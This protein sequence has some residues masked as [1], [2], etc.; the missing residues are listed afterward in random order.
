MNYCLRSSTRIWNYSVCAALLPYDV[1]TYRECWSCTWRRRCSTAGRRGSSWM[2]RSWRS[3]LPCLQTDNRR[4]SV[5]V[6]RPLVPPGRLQVRGSGRSHST[7]PRGLTE[8]SVTLRLRL[9]HTRSPCRRT[10]N[11]PQC[12]SPPH[13]IIIIIIIIIIIYL[14]HQS[15][16]N[17]T[18]SKTDTAALGSEARCALTADLWILHSNWTHR[19]ARPQQHVEY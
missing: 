11:L 15:I 3:S 14:F 7:G 8:C 12:T 4:S 6:G 13:L 19:I 5:Q 2:M 10:H 16:H 18:D 17:E 9:S 1:V